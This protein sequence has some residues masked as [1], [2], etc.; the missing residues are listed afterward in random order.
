MGLVNSGRG[1]LA[2]RAPSPGGSATDGAT[3]WPRKVDGGCPDVKALK[4]R[5][6]DRLD[7]GRDL[8][9]LDRAAASPAGEPD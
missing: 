2:R 8:G 4:Q 1:V 9:H 3:I 6:R 5:V 7:P